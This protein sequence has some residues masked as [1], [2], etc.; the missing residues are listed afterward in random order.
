MKP[1]QVSL[2]KGRAGEKSNLVFEGRDIALEYGGCV[3]P[4][5]GCDEVPSSKE[6]GAPRMA[7]LSIQQCKTP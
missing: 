6:S 5:E 7:F 1:H 4:E 3:E 2:Q